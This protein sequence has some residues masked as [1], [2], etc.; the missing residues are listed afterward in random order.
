[1]ETPAARAVV[2]RL[3]EALNICRDAQIKVIYTAH[4]HRR[5]GPELPVPGKIRSCALKMTALFSCNCRWEVKSSIDY[6]PR[7]S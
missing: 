4:V 2:P 6:S 3:A 1:M 7:I 5:D